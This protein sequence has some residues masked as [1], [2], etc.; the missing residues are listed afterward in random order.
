MVYGDPFCERFSHF[1]AR[2]QW[3]MM[4]ELFKK[5]YNHE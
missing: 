2:M 3:N 4:E 1:V 5:N